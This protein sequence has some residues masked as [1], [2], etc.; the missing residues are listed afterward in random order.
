M[1]NQVLSIPSLLEQDFWDI[2]ANTRLSVPTPEIFSTKQVV[3]FGSGD[4]YNAAVGAVDAF[5]QLCNLNATALTS[6]EASRYYAQ[7]S[8]TEPKKNILAIGISSSGEAART[9]E[10]MLAF[11][12]NG[13]NSLAVSSAPESRMASA[14][15]NVLCVKKSPFPPSPG[16]RSYISTQAAL[17]ALAIRFG[18]V[19]GLYT[20]DQAHEMRR[21]LSG[22]S[23]VIERAFDQLNSELNRFADNCSL[24]K[25]V[26]LLSAGPCKAS[27]DFGMAKMIEAYGFS[28]SS[29]DVE[30][31]AHLNFFRT[32]PEQIPT[33]LIAPANAH[34]I[35]RSLEVAQAVKALNRP[36]IVLTDG[37]DLFS[38]QGNNTACIEA[39]L[40][41]MFSPLVYSSL[42]AYILANVDGGPGCEYFRG[43]KGAWSES[44]FPDVR[45]SKIEY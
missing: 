9:V 38:R 21:E 35:S 23:S 13:Y 26:E 25:K 40:R 27:A 34:A 44:G 18:E 7:I 4:S 1:L 33:I 20:M 41:E 37:E 6:L 32:N 43:H 16:V 39:S 10:A 2:E 5:R 19:K 17:F 29:Q 30:E 14:A 8:K 42:V 28:A 22:L 31:F 24:H 11:A 45:N 15:R 3:L 36:H 12:K